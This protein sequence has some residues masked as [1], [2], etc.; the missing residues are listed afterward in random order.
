MLTLFSHAGDNHL[1]GI[2]VKLFVCEPSA[3]PILDI[4]VISILGVIAPVRGAIR[5]QAGHDF[6]ILY[7]VFRGQRSISTDSGGVGKINLC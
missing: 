6:C 2:S 3:R 1:A 7:C 5:M 4:G